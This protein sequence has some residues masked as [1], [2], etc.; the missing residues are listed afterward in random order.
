MGA[1]GLPSTSALTSPLC[2]LLCTCPSSPPPATL[3]PS[4]GL[5]V[6]YI[7]S[8]APNHFCSRPTPCKGE[9]P[10][11]P[12]LIPSRILFIFVSST[13]ARFQNVAKGHS[14][15]TL[16]PRGV[17]EEKTFFCE[18]LCKA[19]QVPRTVCKAGHLGAL[20]SGAAHLSPE[21]LRWAAR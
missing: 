18:F 2:S 4:S 21:R 7:Y 20:A 3:R 1:P 11:G 17:S 9:H 10:D 15:Q 14:I 19:G 16:E 5:L 6:Y 12:W 8:T 13:H